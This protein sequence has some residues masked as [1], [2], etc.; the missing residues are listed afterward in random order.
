MKANHQLEKCSKNINQLIKQ[1]PKNNFTAHLQT[2][3]AA[4]L[5]RYHTFK[6]LKIVITW[7]TLFR[8]KQTFLSKLD[9]SEAIN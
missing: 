1:R 9:L 3:F 4:I 8:G 7:K 6:R 2:K 5:T